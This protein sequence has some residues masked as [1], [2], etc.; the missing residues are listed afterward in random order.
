MLLLC[1]EDRFP[2]TSR[3]K[4]DGLETNLFARDLPKARRTVQDIEQ[5][6]E[7]DE[8]SSL[9]FTYNQY[10]KESDI[11]KLVKLLLIHKEDL[12]EV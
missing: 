4:P 8:T 10:L 2:T 12:Y 7:Q 9:P 5:D 3:S 1:I 11:R 6:I